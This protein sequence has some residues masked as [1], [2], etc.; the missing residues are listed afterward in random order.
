MKERMKVLQ[1][2]NHSIHASSCTAEPRGTEAQILSGVEGPRHL[3]PCIPIVP[4]D[5]QISFKIL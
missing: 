1:N 2:M 5:V 4:S 3:C